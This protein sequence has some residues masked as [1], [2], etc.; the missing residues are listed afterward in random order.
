ME[1]QLHYLKADVDAAEQASS[2]SSGDGDDMKDGEYLWVN[3][4]R[5]VMR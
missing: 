2:S 1:Y 5:E 4:N 3:P